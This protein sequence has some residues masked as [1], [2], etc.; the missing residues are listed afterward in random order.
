M[1]KGMTEA[2]R[3]AA[4]ADRYLDL[5]ALAAYSGLS[6]RSLRRACAA[7]VNP[8]DYTMVRPTGTGKGRVMVRKRDFDR[9]MENQAV[10]GPQAGRP[11]GAVPPV[12][13]PATDLSWMRKRPRA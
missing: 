12:E 2:E 3:A 9:W 1:R 8:L 11:A 5:E 13:E 7:A 4:E 6:T 10:G